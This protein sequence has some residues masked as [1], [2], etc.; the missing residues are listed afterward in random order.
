MKLIKRIL[1]GPYKS[2]LDT[3]KKKKVIEAMDWASQHYDQTNEIN[4]AARF[5]LILEYLLCVPLTSFTKR[6]SFLDDLGMDE[7]EPVEVAMAIK[8][9]FQIPEIEE[10]DA[11]K[12]QHFDDVVSY[13]IRTMKKPNSEPSGVD[14]IASRRF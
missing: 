5:A 10:K 9:E 4:T 11:E 14:K 2:I 6:T 12:M 8:E 7:L 13:L 3:S 1:R